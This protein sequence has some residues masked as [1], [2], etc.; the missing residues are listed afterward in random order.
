MM[1]SLA[2]LAVVVA[3][4]RAPV[5]VSA[6]AVAPFRS[7]ADAVPLEKLAAQ[8]KSEGD[9]ADPKLVLEIAGRRTKAALDALLDA[10][11][12]MSTTYMQREIARALVLFDG[13]PDAAEPALA[14][15]EELATGAT[16]PAL[17]RAAVDGLGDCHAHGKTHL[18]SVVESKADDGVRERAMELH[19][20]LHDASDASWYR[21]LAQAPAPEKPEKEK[22]KERKGGKNEKADKA[23]K[24]APEDP[25]GG[26]PRPTGTIR[27][28]AFQALAPDLSAEEI[29]EA[30]ADPY[31][32]IRRSALLELERRGDK[33]A[34]ELAEATLA[35]ITP[36][37]SDSM[38]LKVDERVEARVAAAQICGR[39]AGAKMAGD[40]L[41]RGTNADTPMELR[42]TLADILAGLDDP[43]LHRQLVTDLGKGQTEDKLFRL[44]AV[45]G[46]K[47]VKVDRAIE[48]LLLDKDESVVAA[49]CAVLAERKDAEAEPQ[50]AKLIKG[51]EKGVVRAALEATSALRAGDAAWLQE[52]SAYTKSDDPELRSLAIQV[53]GK[54]GDRS[55]LAKLLEG[56]QDVSWSTRLTALLALEGLRDKDAIPAIIDRMALEEGRMRM[57]FAF[58]LWRLTGEPF[59]DRADDWRA[60][61]KRSGESFQLL[62]ESELA[63]VETGEAEW[64]LK[65]TTR[66]DSTVVSKREVPT[67]FGIHVVSHHVTIVFDVSGSM[68][69]KL[70]GVY[71]P[72]GKT[73][74]TRMDVLRKELEKCVRALDP[75]AH[76]NLVSFSKTV[77]IWKSG[78][79][80][81]ATEKNREDALA[82]V[83]QVAPLGSTNLYDALKTAFADPEVDTIIVISDGEPTDGAQTDQLIIREHVKRWNE[84]RRIVIDTIAAGGQ[85]QILQ[86]LAA[87]SGGAHVHFE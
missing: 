75:E 71:E 32:G 48:K 31:F 35:K 2:A 85:F 67:F 78:G 7:Q 23:E 44:W 25:S 76:F 6:R 68:N 60:W 55:H 12:S 26:K 74:Y 58:A 86:W 62:T 64:R 46:M 47:D 8:L 34:L 83:A 10:Y 70:H 50:L 59:Q 56:L 79:L 5:G 41:K 30:T 38:I 52:L 37:D 21:D 43:S 82:W 14:K 15:L 11:P 73:G 42:R 80:V 1:A 27:G 13:V 9:R 28:L 72:T 61:W 84:Q 39:L 19:V 18:A 24:N 57:E 77:E 4:A 22:K 20:T 63:R 66:V 45:R 87:D 17:R 69:E 40:F 54:T 49:A 16:E 36:L 3:S 51:K 29:V 33:R 65:Q 53:L 81:P